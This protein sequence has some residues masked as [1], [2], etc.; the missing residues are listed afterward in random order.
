MAVIGYGLAGRAFHAP[1]IAA[2]EGM[3]SGRGRDGRRDGPP[4]RGRAP[5]RAGGGVGRRAVGGPEALDLV[6]VAAPNRHHVPLARAA[7]AAGLAVV[8][9]KPLAPS[10]AE[11]RAL[12]EEARAAGV[13]LSVFHNRRWDGDF[14]TL[15]RLIA[16]GALGRP[17]R[18]ESRFERWRPE[19]DAG[20]WREL[21]DPA[22]GGGLLADLGSHLIDQAIAL[23]GRP[24]A[25][26]AEL[27]ARRPGARW[28]TTASSPSPT[29]G[30]AQP[31]LGQHARSR[32]PP[33]AA[34]LGG[35]WVKR[36]LDVQEAALRAGAR[37]GGPGWGAEPERR[38][39]GACTMAP[40]PGSCRP[41]PA[42]TPRSTPGWPVR[43]AE[44]SAA[45]GPGGRRRGPRGH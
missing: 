14:L 26:H 35:V 7:I 43:C 23:F 16:E 18:V 17:T 25:V 22:E 8:V 4:P 20:R 21:A 37:P 30:R 3:A 13:V 27:L 2:T 6:V 38:P 33:A 44:G 45:G 32:R 15:R 10:A 34:G 1:L 31:S 28:T 39:G 5:G 41:S 24:V 40:A 11:G 36:G 9:D 42:T 19:V 12:A 29:R